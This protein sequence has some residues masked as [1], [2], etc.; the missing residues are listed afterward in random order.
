MENAVDLGDSWAYSDSYYD[1]PLL[2]AVG[3]PVVG[4]PRPPPAAS[5]RSCDAGRSSTST[6][7]PACPKLP[8]S[9]SSRSRRSWRWPGPS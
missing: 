9:A 1:I 5:P 8:C 3:H 7:P 6:C 4:Q 2:S